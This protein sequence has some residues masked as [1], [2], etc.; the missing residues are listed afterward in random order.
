M[1][2][3]SQT[4]GIKSAMALYMTKQRRHHWSDHSAKPASR[5]VIPAQ[6]QSTESSS[7]LPNTDTS[8]RTRLLLDT[9]FVSNV[10]VYC[11]DYSPPKESSSLRD[12]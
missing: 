2:K 4:V 9:S 10:M 12:E 8:L 5:Q 1:L 7:H 11:A 6:S 3:I